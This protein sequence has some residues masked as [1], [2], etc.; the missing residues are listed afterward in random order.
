MIKFK[1]C[2][3]N[4]IV[5]FM[6]MNLQKITNYNSTFTSSQ[7]LSVHFA[8]VHEGENPLKCQIGEASSSEAVKFLLQREY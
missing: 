5:N 8:A 7:G 6:V 1:L 4:I 3:K 2:Q